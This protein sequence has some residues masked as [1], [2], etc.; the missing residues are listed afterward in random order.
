MKF[1]LNDIKYIESFSKLK[2]YSYW[3]LFLI[4]FILNDFTVP[5]YNPNIYLEKISQIIDIYLPKYRENIEDI[6]KN[7]SIKY[8]KENNKYLKQSCVIDF[9]D[10]VNLELCKLYNKIK[11][12]N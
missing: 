1:S 10:K 2:P 8:G 7:D 12:N 9:A 4:E 6:Y 5:L 11:E 3:E